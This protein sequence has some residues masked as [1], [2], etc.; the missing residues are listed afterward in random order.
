MCLVEIL[1]RSASAAMH[2]LARRI[3]SRLRHIDP[4]A[5]ELEEDMSST[6]GTSQHMDSSLSVKIDLETESSHEDPSAHGIETLVEEIDTT[7]PS[8]TTSTGKLHPHTFESTFNISRCP[9]WAAS[10]HRIAA[11]PHQ[12]VRPGR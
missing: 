2:A 9:V 6:D 12:P 11:R 5:S 4:V 1:R 10:Y 3:F 7:T 8:K